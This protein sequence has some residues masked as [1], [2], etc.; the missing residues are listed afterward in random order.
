M[1]RMKLAWENLLRCENTVDAHNHV[2]FSAG[3]ENPI[4]LHGLFADFSARLHGG[5]S[6]PGFRNRARIFGP[7][8]NLLRVIATCISIRFLSEPGLKSQ[9]ANRAG[10]SARAEI[11]HVIRPEGPIH[12]CPFSFEN[13]TFSLPIRLPSTRIR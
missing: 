12:T 4:R 11:R 8:W 3:A 7:R 5:K 6:Y 1:T 9:P 2:P 13:A 10:I